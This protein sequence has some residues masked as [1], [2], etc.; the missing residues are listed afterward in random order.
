MS[1]FHAGTS[2]QFAWDS[3]SLGWF[4]SCPRLYYYHQIRGFTSR[5]MSPHLVF[6]IHY[7]SALE[8]YDRERAT[9]A[10]HDDAEIAVLHKLLTDTF[11]WE[12]DHNLKNRL[13]LIRS[14]IWYLEEFREDKAE[15]IILANGKPAVELSFKLPLDDG[16]I[17]CGHLDRVVNFLDGQYV[18]DRKTSTSTLSNYYFDRYEPDNQMSL[19]T[20]AA[21]II[22]KA[23]VKGVIIDAAQVAV[24]FTAF[25]RGMTYRTPGQ[26]EEWLDA[27][28][29]YIA[30]AQDMAEE[31]DHL[32]ETKGEAVALRAFPMN[33]KSCQM[34]GSCVFRGIC[35]KDPGV[36]ENFLESNFEVRRWNPLEER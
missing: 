28:K 30:S 8:H 14:V 33:D 34:Y 11:G 3:T 22:Y 17:I 1:P 5:G 15:T 36:R 9:G 24:G 6:G 12:S 32:R 35:S 29:Q 19:Y 2:I 7:H 25:S 13:N 31:Y 4:K 21:Q 16:N 10:S 20:F 23:P 26:L 27:T 18:M